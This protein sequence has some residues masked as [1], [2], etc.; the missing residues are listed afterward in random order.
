MVITIMVNGLMTRKKE[1][2]AFTIVKQ[3][4]FMKVIGL[5]MKKVARD[6]WLNTPMVDKLFKDSGEMEKLK[7]RLQF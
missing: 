7:G 5:K 1:L 4:I 3:E 6:L 2:V